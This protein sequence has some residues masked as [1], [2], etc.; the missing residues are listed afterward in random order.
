[1]KQQL[2]IFATIAAVT[3]L[4]LG[5]AI[6]S[7]ANTGWIEVQNKWYYYDADGN[8]I[9]NQ[10]V[11]N[12]GNL[13]WL[14]DNGEMAKQTW[15]NWD[16]SWFWV[17]AQG[18]MIKDSWVP[19]AKDWYYVGEDGKMPTSTWLDKDGNTYYITETGAVAKG[20]R[21]ISGNWHYFDV[22]NGDMKRDTTVGGY[23]INREGIYVQ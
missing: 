23:K 1:M 13:F 22:T 15:V 6:T 17:N 9:R 10:W 8:S 16:N 18:A 11:E 2:K 19:V 4:T 5:L 3:V 20:W 7:F 21:E 12:D 14:K